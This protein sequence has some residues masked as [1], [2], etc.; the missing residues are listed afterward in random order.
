ERLRAGRTGRRRG[1]RVRLHSAAVDLL[2]GWRATD[3]EQENLRRTYLE[4]LASGA[5]ALRRTGR[6]AHLTASALIVDPSAEHTLLVLHAKLGL[7]VQP[8]GHCEP[9]DD[10]LVATALREAREETGVA[11]LRI[12]R[13]P[14][15][16]SAHPAPCGAE[17]HYDVQF[18]VVAPRDATPSASTESH[19]VRW[20]GLHELP[21]ALAAGVD[22]SV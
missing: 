21:T 20:F 4:R 14:A 8:G 1:P 18:P 22:E 11:D 9:G 7:W 10:S 13:T 5:D 2:T 12:H 17:L 19:A 15:R 16:L 3:P 6:P